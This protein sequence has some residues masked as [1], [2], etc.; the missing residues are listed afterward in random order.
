MKNKFAAAQVKI[1]LFTR[2][3][4]KKSTFFGLAVFYT[5]GVKQEMAGVYAH[6]L[7]HKKGLL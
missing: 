6:P 7:C 1:F 3:S 2:I 5:V 4:G